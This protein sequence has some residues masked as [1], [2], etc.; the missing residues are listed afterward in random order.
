MLRV[1]DLRVGVGDL[2]L[3]SWGLYVETSWFRGW[4]FRVWISGFGGVRLGAWGLALRVQCLGS[5]VEDSRR[6]RIRSE[7]FRVQGSGFRIQSSGFR[8]S[9]FRE[10]WLG[11][12]RI[13]SPKTT[14]VL[15]H[16]PCS[17]WFGVQGSG[18]GV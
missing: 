17:T 9:G 6:L 11:S 8:G 10:T 13:S 7:E 5:S 15:V 12:F 14:A 16:A 1:C 4:G 2:R 18:S 3:G